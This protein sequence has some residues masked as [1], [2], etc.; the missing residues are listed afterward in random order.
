MLDGTPVLPSDTEKREDIQLMLLRK[1][2]EAEAVRDASS[3]Q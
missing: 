2:K 1:Y 3:A